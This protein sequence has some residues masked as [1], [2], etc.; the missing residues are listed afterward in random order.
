[1]SIPEQFSENI[2]LQRSILIYF[3]IFNKL[4]RLQEHSLLFTQFKYNNNIIN[5]S[6]LKIFKA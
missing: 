1:M 4:S 6:Y 3:L 2:E 5:K